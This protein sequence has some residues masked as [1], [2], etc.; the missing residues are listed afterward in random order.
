MNLVDHRTE[1]GGIV[2]LRGYTDT[3]MVVCKITPQSHSISYGGNPYSKPI[4]IHTEIGATYQVTWLD[5]EN[6]P[7]T[8]SYSIDC[9]YARYNS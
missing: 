2:Y 4:P 5:K 9:L 6:R 1:V 8:A 3:P 7:C